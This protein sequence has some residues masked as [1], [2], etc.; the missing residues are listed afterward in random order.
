[1]DEILPLFPLNVV[2]FPGMQLPLH[3]FEQRYRTMIG[4]CVASERLFGVVLIRAG[5]E[6]GAPAEPRVIGTK[7]KIMSVERLPDGRM[8]IVV[9]GV[10]RFAIRELVAGEP[11]PRARIETLAD[12]TADANGELSGAVLSL[13]TRC[14]EEA[15]I[16]PERLQGLRL[17]DEPLA[18]SYVVAAALKVPND[19]RQELL[20]QPSAGA[21]LRHELQLLRWEAGGPRRA[22]AGPFSLN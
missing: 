11:Y 22:N 3:I 17:P 13:F 7:A 15:G 9:V 14:L 6:A 10:E 1:M 16:A 19:L 12:E 21:R 20:E 18:L 2:L 5:E 8:N 4:S